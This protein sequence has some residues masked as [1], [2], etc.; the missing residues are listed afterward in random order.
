MAET[1][2]CILIHEVSRKQNLAFGLLSFKDILSLNRD[3][4]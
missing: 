4:C 3:W 1:D 2:S